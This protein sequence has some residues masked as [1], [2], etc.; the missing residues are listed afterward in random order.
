MQMS[1]V[2]YCVVLPFSTSETGDLISGQPVEKQT[3]DAARR[4]AIAL[5][6]AGTAGA[7]AFQRTGD[8]SLGESKTRS[9]FLEKA[10]FQTTFCFLERGKHAEQGI[11]SNYRHNP[12]A[13]NAYAPDTYGTDPYAGLA[14]N[15]I[16]GRSRTY[17]RE[18]TDHPFKARLI[19]ATLRSG[20]TGDRDDCTACI[21][22]TAAR[23]PLAARSIGC[24]ENA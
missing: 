15:G 22:A 6:A 23:L 8:P 7:I 24:F 3:A 4:Y 1:S 13:P 14:R 18:A 19:L 2:T 21:C 11:R 5:V 20:V 10:L 16:R 9:L 17:G 12:F